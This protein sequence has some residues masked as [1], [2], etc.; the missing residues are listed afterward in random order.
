[1]VWLGDTKRKSSAHIPNQTKKNS[2]QNN[3]YR[4]EIGL[5]ED[6]C[7][8]DASISSFVGVK[9]KTKEVIIL[10]TFLIRSLSFPIQ[11]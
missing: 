8:E 9:K 1:M 5:D 7:H 2:N 4:Y 10:T 11:K 6:R 3:L